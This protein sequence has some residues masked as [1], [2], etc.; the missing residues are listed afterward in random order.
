MSEL[1][2]DEYELLNVFEMLWNVVAYKEE[3]SLEGFN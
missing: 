3:K 2:D 1:D